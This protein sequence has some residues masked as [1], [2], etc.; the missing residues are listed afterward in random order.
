MKYDRIGDV[1]LQEIL[2]RDQSW[3]LIFFS[4][5]GSIPCNH[6]RPEFSAI[7]RHFTATIYCAEINVEENPS[8]ADKLQILAVPTTLLLHKGKELGRYEGPYSH[9]ALIERITPLLKNSQVEE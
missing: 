5:W 9:E 3:A 2:D 7:T 6:F 4:C 1:E 8:I